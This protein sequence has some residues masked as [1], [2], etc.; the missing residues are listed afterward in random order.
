MTNTTIFRFAALASI[1]VATAASAQYTTV[2]PGAPM[3][4]TIAPGPVGVPGG[5]DGTIT[6]SSLGDADLPKDRD[7]PGA[8]TA[9]RKDAA[10]PATAAELIV[11][12]A[13]ADNKGADVGYIKAVD[14]TGVVV[15][16]VGGQVRVPAEAFGKN[17]K[18][19]LIGMS[20]ADFDKLVA[21]A[22]AG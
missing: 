9:S 5:R 2:Q 14:P 8:S 21:S 22:T 17:K 13:I 16:T 12:A 10:R 15:A 4:P 3:N 11:G 7:R 18:G 6:G 19:L 20:K 1:A